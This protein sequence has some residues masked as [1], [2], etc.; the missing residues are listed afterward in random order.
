MKT[1]EA[2]ETLSHYAYCHL[3]ERKD[4]LHCSIYVTTMEI[5]I[6]LLEEIQA[7]GQPKKEKEK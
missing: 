5:P 2:L 1:K 3:N 7:Q 4:D 6:S